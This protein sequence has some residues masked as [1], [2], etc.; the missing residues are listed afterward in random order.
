MDLGEFRSGVGLFNLPDL[1]ISILAKITYPLVLVPRFHLGTAF[2]RLC[3]VEEEAR[4]S[5]LAFPGRA[6]EREKP[7][8]PPNLGGF[9]SSARFGGLG[10]RNQCILSMVQDV[11]YTQ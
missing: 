5:T 8:N 9:R 7:P 3:R 1:G 2:A 4:A 11:S 10:G 6:W